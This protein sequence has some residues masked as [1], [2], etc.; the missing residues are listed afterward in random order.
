[1]GGALIP[2][3]QGVSADLVDLRFSFI[4][5]FICDLY[6]LLVANKLEKK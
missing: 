4:I 5:P 2:L 1:V 3:L 6:I